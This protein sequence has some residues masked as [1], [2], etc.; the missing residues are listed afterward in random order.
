MPSS[1]RHTFFFL[2]GD[3]QRTVVVACI[4]FFGF[5]NPL[6]TLRRQAQGDVVIRE[7]S[8]SRSS[9]PY[10]PPSLNYLVFVIGGLRGIRRSVF[11]CAS[12][13]SKVS[14]YLLLCWTC[15][16]RLPRW[17]RPVFFS[18]RRNINIFYIPGAATGIFIFLLLIS[19]PVPISG[20]IST[21]VPSILKKKIARSRRQTRLEFR[22]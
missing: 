20:G 21:T 8:T 1:S 17:H 3:V 9:L 15:L 18:S 12:Y 5:Y 19:F 2:E 4:V 10:L 11:C 6:G 16:A 22:G 13:T 14:I 7:A